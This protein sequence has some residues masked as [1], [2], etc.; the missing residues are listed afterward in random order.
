[1]RESNNDTHQTEEAFG[2]PQ[3]QLRGIISSVNEGYKT[4]C[5][6]KTNVLGKKCDRRHMMP[7]SERLYNQ[8]FANPNKSD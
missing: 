5:K 8:N 3:D 7:N 1:M 2:V 4:F 6:Q